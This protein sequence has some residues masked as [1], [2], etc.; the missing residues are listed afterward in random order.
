MIG[1]DRLMDI[2]GVVGAGQFSEDGQ[3]I[4]T[5]GEFPEDMM[6]SGEQCVQQAK[7]AEAL[8]QKLNADSKR[9][10]L[11]LNGW[12]VWGGDYAVLVVGNTRV[13]VEV[14]YADFNQLLVDMIGSEATG[15]RPMNY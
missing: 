14:K 13:F 8:V 7:S 6:Q 5:V 12:A 9:N 11:P 10:W 3:V 1:L 4:R 15:P 2:K